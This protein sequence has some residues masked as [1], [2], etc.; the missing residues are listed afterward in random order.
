M[1]SMTERLY[2]SE[3]VDV[4]PGFENRIT[5]KIWRSPEWLDGF[6]HGFEANNGGANMLGV[7]VLMIGSALAGGLFVFCLFA[8]WG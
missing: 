1:N 3:S 6:D 8:M 4:P 2:R 7:I 5:P